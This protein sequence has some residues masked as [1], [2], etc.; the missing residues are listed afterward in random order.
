MEYDEQDAVNFILSKVGVEIDEDEILNVIDIIWD[1]YEDNG[2][3]EI[4]V[5]PT[6]DSIGE[7]ENLIAHAIKL[8][9]KDKSSILSEDVVSKIVLAELEYE[10]TLD[11]Y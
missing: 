6:D 9:K 4:D 7:A 2:L 1:Y 5:N 10:K 8:L 3:L 11:I